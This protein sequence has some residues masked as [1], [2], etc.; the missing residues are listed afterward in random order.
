MAAPICKSSGAN[1]PTIF[2]AQANLRYDIYFNGVL[3]EVRFG[4]GGPVIAY[5]EFGENSVEVIA[6]D[7]AGN[8]SAPATVTIFIP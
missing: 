2:D 3:E 8:E 1:P 5:G 6:S 4:S 7:T